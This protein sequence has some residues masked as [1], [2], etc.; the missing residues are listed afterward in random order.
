MKQGLNK[1]DI[2]KDK[3]IEKIIPKLIGAPAMDY[4]LKEDGLL[5]VIDQQGKKRRFL[6]EEYKAQNAE[7]AVSTGRRKVRKPAV[8]NAAKTEHKAPPEKK[9]ISA[10]KARSAGE[11]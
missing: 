2:M 11:K 8:K 7:R 1:E 4:D 6:P 3:Q 5:V 10:R 9:A